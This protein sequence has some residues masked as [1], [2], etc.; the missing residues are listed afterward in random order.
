M[1]KI[2]GKK[3]RGRQQ[4]KYIESLKKWATIKSISNN[5]MHAADNN[6]VKWRVVV[7][8]VSS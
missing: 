2:D 8:N 3:G 7:T 4:L 6:K 1:K 5:F